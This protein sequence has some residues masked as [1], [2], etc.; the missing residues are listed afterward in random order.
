[1]G[2]QTSLFVRGGDSDDNKVLIDGVDAGDLGNQFDFGPLSTTAVESAPKSIADLIRTSTAPARQR[3]RQ[4][5]HTAR[6]HQLSFPAVS[7]RC[8]QLQHLA[9]GAGSSRRAQQAR[10]SGRLQL[11]ADRQRFAQR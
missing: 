8:R 4:P 11:A 10:L 1:M 6:H 9:R 2:A 7:G 5:D 3:R